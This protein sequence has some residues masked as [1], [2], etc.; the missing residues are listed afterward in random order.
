[1]NNHTCYT[2]D[3][4]RISNIF[5]LVCAIIS[6]ITV[7]LV[8]TS[9]IIFPKL[10]KSVSLRFI[11]FLMFSNLLYSVGVIG[12]IS[13]SLAG[14]NYGGL[15][16]YILGMI[17]NYASILWTLA[18][19]LTILAMVEERLDFLEKY[20]ALLIISIFGI[21][22]TM[23]YLWLDYD[24]LSNSQYLDLNDSIE[25]VYIPAGV[26]CIL[27]GM[28]LYMVRKYIKKNFEKFTANKMFI[29]LMWYPL[30]LLFF[31]GLM[32]AERIIYNV[33]NCQSF[34][35]MIIVDLRSAQGLI[36]TIIY[37]FNPT[38]RKEIASHGKRKNSAFVPSR[39]QSILS[40]SLENSITLN[41]SE[42]K[43]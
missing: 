18:I 16:F 13:I 3:E 35:I 9:Y 22:I 11:A 21:S 30:T 40:D 17:G 38:F 15:T 7:F 36:D 32:V 10:R 24:S 41:E 43:I 39:L 27:L 5:E 31:I 42:S 26:V 29:E 1:M 4:S 23:S 2:P 8:L 33:S 12:Q 34:M 20:Q 25:I 28:L 14:K 6:F 19:G 37:G